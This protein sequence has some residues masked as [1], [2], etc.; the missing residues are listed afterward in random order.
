MAR[1]SR[2]PRVVRSPVTAPLRSMSA[3]GTSVVPCTTSATALPSRSP[4][5]RST[6]SAT[7]SEGAAGVVRTLPTPATCPPRSSTRSV[8]VPPM[9]TPMR[10]PGSGKG[11]SLD[12]V[13][14]ARPW[15][16]QG[17]TEHESAKTCGLG[18]GS[19][20]EHN[21]YPAGMRFGVLLECDRDP[22]A[23]VEQ[24]ELLEGLGYASVWVAEHH[25]TA[26]YVPQPLM[27][28]AA[29]AT[30]TR[31]LQ[32]GTYVVVLP[33]YDPVLVAEQAAM[34]DAFSGGRLVL[35]VGL[36]YVREEFAGHGIPFHHRVGR[37][38]EALPLLRRLFA[39]EEVEHAG[40]HFRIVH[41]RLHPG[42]VQPGGPPIWLGG[43][44]EAAV[45]RAARLA[46][47]W[48]PGPTGDLAALRVGFDVYDD[49]RRRLGRPLPAGRVACR[50]LFCAPSSEQ[51]RR[52]GGTAL[53]RFYL[54]TYLRWPHPV[55]GGP[56]RPRYE[57]LARDRFLVGDPEECAE[58]VARLAEL[59]VDHLV[60]RAQAPGLAPARAIESLRL[61]A[62]RVMPR[63]TV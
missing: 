13:R 8:K 51:A 3:L 14:D 36:G 5:S 18:H 22:R 26:G 35:G 43:W 58:G 41:P 38:E 55:L 48:V 47:A 40:R 30:R 34:V 6:P 10:V 2:N 57:E 4:S 9:S 15:P 21:R 44:V 50:E 59:G 63:F 53:H 7:A 28:L 62:E 27:A 61:F 49:E 31:R 60:L 45:R 20:H 39:G 12:P 17:V 24:A 46:D 25:G 42:P 16:R 54:N 56:G 32:L 33:L 19:A 37:L 23:A 1:V 11:R 52:L 29:L